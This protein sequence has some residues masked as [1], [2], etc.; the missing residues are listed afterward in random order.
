MA[1]GDETEDII[2]KVGVAY[3]A[4]LLLVKLLLP[5][6]GA[7]PEEKAAIDSVDTANPVD[8]P[9]SYNYAPFVD[10][11]NKNQNGG[12]TITDS[13]IAAKQDWDNLN[14]V[15]PLDWTH[16]NIDVI[17]AAE[18]IKDGFAW[19]KVHITGNTTEVLSVLDNIPTKIILAAVSSA[20]WVLYGIDLWT[21]LKQGSALMWRGLSTS[22][23][24]LVVDKMNALPIG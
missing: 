3:G 15:P 9:F 17:T 21:Y 14:P 22:D 19:Y 12:V 20:L 6:F 23:L 16:G 18:A 4:F 1:K 10:A 5:T 11:F 13:L 2:I 7:S 8:N 24:K